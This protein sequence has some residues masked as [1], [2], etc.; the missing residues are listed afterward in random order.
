MSVTDV[1]TTVLGDIALILFVSTLLGGLARRLGQPAV[2]G[3][4]L[5]GV[6]LGPTLLG[7][8]PG[9]PTARLF[10]PE[11]LPY[12]SVLAQVAIVT[13]MFVVGYELNLRSIR[14]SGRAT[15]SVAAG[16]LVVPMIL[17][18]GAVQFLPSA[19]T[20]V[21]E[22]DVGSRSFVLF[23]AVTVS[24]TALP[25]LAAIIRSTG[26][27]GTRAGVIALAAAGLMDIGAWT[28][29]A[30]AMPG[31][32]HGLPVWL[33]V[34][35][36][37]ALVLGGFLVVRPLLRR[38]ID[39]P[40]GLFTSQLPLA[41]FL[42]TSCAWA[43]SELGLHAIFG[44]FLAGLL[45]PRR[46]GAPDADVLRAMEGATDLLLP[47]F[48]VVTGLSLNIGALDRN[49]VLLLCLVLLISVVGKLVPGY[50]VSRLNGLERR[51][52]ATVAALLNTRGLTEL[53][54]LNV[55]LSAGIIH[56]R[57]FTVL[58]LMALIT[59]AMTSPLLTLLGRPRHSASAAGEVVPAGSRKE[60]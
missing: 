38:W 34:L 9:N 42:A 39:R 23:F 26:I 30:V 33:T 48:F 3:Q 41:I 1:T 32:A 2:I 16:A 35:L 50:L 60:T 28:A 19:F 5:T 24:I 12:L 21:G 25:V 11:V 36:T 52:S 55:G 56:G 10:P 20:A 6:M 4:I 43:T 51:D 44:G 54:A 29:L 14:A 58:A 22:H 57:L 59:T 27:A 31:D 47:L 17:G 46:D 15:L 18:A 37:L 8:L 7:R 40:D 45:M 53:I 13:F 49:S